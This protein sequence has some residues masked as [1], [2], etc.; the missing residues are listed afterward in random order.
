MSFHQGRGRAKA[1][2]GEASKRIE[3]QR[4]SG[5]DHEHAEKAEA[6]EAEQSRVEAPA[7]DRP[8]NVDGD[9]PGSDDQE[10][11]GADDGEGFAHGSSNVGS[12]LIY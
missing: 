6:G 2:D 3:Q 4:K 9:G 8:G 12:S 1:L 11:G 5:D 10:D 7:R